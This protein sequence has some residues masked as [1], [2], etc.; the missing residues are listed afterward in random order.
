[1]FAVT[2][3][4]VVSSVICFMV[5]KHITTSRKVWGA[6]ASNLKEELFF[7]SRFLLIVT[8][9]FA[10]LGVGFASNAYSRLITERQDTLAT[11]SSEDEY[12]SR[13]S[14]QT[15]MIAYNIKKA[16]YNDNLQRTQHDKTSVSGF[17]NFGFLISDA[18]MYLKPLP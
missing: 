16:E 9:L 6:P 15:R 2:V 11:I 12:Y 1:M 8:V 3:L 18:V 14:E 7:W 10:F 4:L 13:F 5:A 17:W